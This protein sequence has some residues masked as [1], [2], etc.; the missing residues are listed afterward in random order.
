MVVSSINNGDYLKVQ[1]VDFSKG[2]K[3]VEVSV[4]S[5]NGGTIEIHTDSSDGQLLEL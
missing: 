5:M 1:G 4:A 3:S 2:I